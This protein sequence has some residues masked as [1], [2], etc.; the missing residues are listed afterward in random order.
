MS[1]ENIKKV[2][3]SGVV[4]GKL[5][6]GQR[7]KVQVLEAALKNYARLGI[8]GTTFETVADRSPCHV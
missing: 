8:E 2:I 7:R 4:E 3:A 5:T 1:N 6:K